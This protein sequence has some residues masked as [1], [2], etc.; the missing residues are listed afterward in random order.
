LIVNERFLSRFVCHVGHWPTGE[1]VPRM[2][3][4]TIS[5]FTRVFGALWFAA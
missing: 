2:R 3:R 5:A 4:S 1:P